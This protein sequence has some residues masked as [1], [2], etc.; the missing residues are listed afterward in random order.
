M[1]ENF[2]ANMQA[3]RKCLQ[4]VDQKLPRKEAKIESTLQKMKEKK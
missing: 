1:G 3:P 4:P 2:V